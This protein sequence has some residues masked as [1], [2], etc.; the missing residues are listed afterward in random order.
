MKRLGGL[1]EQVITFE[2]LLVAFQNAFRASPQ[3]AEAHRYWLNLEEET[4]LL[5]DELRNGEFVPGPY[6]YFEIRDPKQRNIAVA[7]FRDRV[8]HH[9]V[10]RVLEPIY[11][12]VFIFD[13]YATRVGKGTHRAIERAQRFLR[14]NTW[15]VKADVEKFFDS[16]DHSV[17][18][19]LVSKKI[20]DGSVIRLLEKIIRT[21][22][23]EIGIPI[24]NLT[25]Q[26]LANVY[27]DPLDHFVK[28]E[29]GW[30]DYLRYMDDFVLFDRDKTR[31]WGMRFLIEDFLRKE[32]KLR[33]KPRSIVHLRTEEGLGFLG[34]SIY[35]NLIRMRT[36]NLGRALRKMRRKIRDL[37]ADKCDERDL[38]AS[39]TSS[40]G[41]LRYFCPRF[42]VLDC[43]EGRKRLE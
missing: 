42:P 2:N 12:R 29:I 4:F 41:H 16:V 1:F 3:S 36:E 31:L 33:L 19:E 35:P 5:R 34:M 24:G 14:R 18:L 22:D 10:V 9:A 15:F 30:G 21:Y 13:S 17:L 7:P 38:E 32:L 43:L 20:K 8:V 6:R 11:E 39:L 27:L 40:T 37:A 25:S 28:D 26:F 23:R